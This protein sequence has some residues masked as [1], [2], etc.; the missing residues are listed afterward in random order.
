MEDHQFQLDTKGLGR[1]TRMAFIAHMIA[2]MFIASLIGYTAVSTTANKYSFN[3][4]QGMLQDLSAKSNLLYRDTVTSSKYWDQ[5]DS[6]IKYLNYNDVNHSCTDYSATDSQSNAPIFDKKYLAFQNHFENLGFFM[7]N[8]GYHFVSPTDSDKTFLKV[9]MQQ[10]LVRPDY[11][12][13][14]PEAGS[15]KVDF[16]YFVWGVEKG[17]TNSE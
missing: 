15:G 6:S 2:I 4:V 1:C 3:Y 13:V 14:N 10:I 7:G 5:K 16:C 8:H 11:C 12:E 17:H 9:G